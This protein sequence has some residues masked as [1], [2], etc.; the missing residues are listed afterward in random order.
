MREVP[1]Y[2][3]SAVETERARRQ[4][5]R[6]PQAHHTSKKAASKDERPGLKAIHNLL[7]PPIVLKALDSRWLQCALPGFRRRS[8][9]KFLIQ[10]G[11]QLGQ[12]LIGCRTGDIRHHHGTEIRFRPDHYGCEIHPVRSGALTLVL[13]TNR[14]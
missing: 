4:T 7:L 6:I 14:G 3:E 12:R 5:A 8:L 13:M 9:E 1:T 11:C 10:I 2:I